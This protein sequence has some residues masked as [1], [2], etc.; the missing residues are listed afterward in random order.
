M[1]GDQ[2]LTVETVEGID[3]VDAAAWDACAGGANPFVGHAFLAALEVSR[4]VGGRSG[5]QPMHVVAR[6]GERVVGVVPMY[7][8]AHSYGEYVFD[9]GWAQAYERAG[10]RYYPKLQV[11]VPLHAGAGPA[12]A[13]AA[14]CAGRHAHG[15]GH[16][17][18]RDRAPAPRV[19][20][21]RHVLQRR[22]Q[23]GVRRGRAG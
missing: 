12:P 23:R 10:G 18:R 17:A 13:G 11:A 19:L 21:A 2:Q 4:S 14:G 3:A 5:W 7:A 6:A 22:R 1:D 16:G 20:A 9:H 8:K 15:A